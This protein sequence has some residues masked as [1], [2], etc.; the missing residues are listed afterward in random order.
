[1][2]FL[3]KNRFTTEKKEEKDLTCWFKEN[4]E[5]FTQCLMI[6]TRFL[7]KGKFKARKIENKCQNKL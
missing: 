5:S 4:K 6:I 3:K 1:M 2:G 7:Y